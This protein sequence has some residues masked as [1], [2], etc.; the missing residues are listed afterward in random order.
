MIAPALTLAL[1]LAMAAPVQAAIAP[2]TPQALRAAQQFGACVADTSTAKASETLAQDFRTPAYRR[3]MDVLVEVNRGCPSFRG[4]SRM[5][6]SRLLFAGAVA[7]RLIERD[8]RP[9][10]VALARAAAGPVAASY[11]PSDAAAMCVVRSVPDD[12]A[13]L[14]A[15]DV[16]TPE[17]GGAA[18]AL[19][20]VFSRCLQD[21]PVEVNADGLRAMLAT[22]AFRS[23]HAAMARKS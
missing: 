9:V 10:N 1:T 23:I 17:E 18:D 12:V 16:A 7:E 21:R 4:Y 3:A 13:K 11:S 22:A 6:V 19:K 14:F 5:R 20:P 15:T 8:G 2:S